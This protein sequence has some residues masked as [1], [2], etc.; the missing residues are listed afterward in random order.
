MEYK[1]EW[2]DVAGSLV[3]YRRRKIGNLRKERSNSL[4][5]DVFVDP[6]RRSGR[7]PERSRRRFCESK[8]Y[9]RS[10]SISW[11]IP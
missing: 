2:A 3:K 8:I 1:T 7:D 11:W 4:G 5:R 10:S 9:A 6:Y